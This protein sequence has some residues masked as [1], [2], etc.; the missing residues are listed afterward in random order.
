M[1]NIL[2]RPETPADIDAI[3]DLTEQAFAPMSFSD[4]NDYVLTDNLRKD[5]DLTLSLVATQNNDIIGHAAFSPV[6]INAVHNRW[7][8][9][10]PISVR[11]DKQKQGIGTALTHAGLKLLRVQNANGCALVGNP[12][13]YAPM[14]FIS[15]GLLA[16]ENLAPDL[17]Q[18]IH[19]TGP[20][21]TGTLKF[22]P[23]FTEKT[24]GT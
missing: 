14:G 10:G 23:A 7:F 24:E 9:L 16:Y 4:A 22:A 1:K 2:I 19:F 20:Q 18:F 8:G 21:P 6:T 3:R 11:A 17:V 12:A 15:N 13:V 5:G